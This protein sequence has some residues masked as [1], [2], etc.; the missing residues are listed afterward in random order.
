MRSYAMEPA[1]EQYE[2]HLRLQVRAASH[3]LRAYSADLRQFAEF[4]QGEG[5]SLERTDIQVM[6][7]YL[8]T[9]FGRRSRST[10]ARKL[11]A[12][13]GF[14][15]FCVRTGVLASDPLE[16]IA[17]PK[18]EKR[19]PSYLTVDEMFRTIEGASQGT[20]LCLRDRAIL[21]VLYSCG[22]RV[23]ELVGLDWDHIQPQARA[24]RV[25]GKGGKE[26]VVPIGEVALEALGRYRQAWQSKQLGDR[27]AVFLNARGGRLSARSVARIVSYWAKKA[28]T[29]SAVS[30]HSI[31]HSFATHLLGS[32]A[33]LRSIQELLGHSRLSTTQRYTHVDF[34]HI[35]RVYDKS[36]PRA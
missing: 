28:K 32:G 25:R 22:L 33:D 14:F 9:L 8:A 35:A 12:L 10:L 19:L 2:E 30:P 1:I 24:L 11:S 31:R 29:R 6:R 26:R 3:T 36:H 18:L 21:E 27:R 7:R 20:P 4:L 16:G 13:R 34:S 17:S 15:R 23:S 5:I